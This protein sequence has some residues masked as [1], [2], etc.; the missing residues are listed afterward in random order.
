MENLISP[1]LKTKNHIIELYRSK[2]VNRVEPACFKKG[3][4]CLKKFQ[5]FAFHPSPFL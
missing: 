1:L 3:Y 2:R 5:A 4:F